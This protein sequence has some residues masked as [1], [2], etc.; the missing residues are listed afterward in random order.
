MANDRDQIT[1]FKSNQTN[2]F[3]Y[4]NAAG[5]WEE[6]VAEGSGGGGGASDVVI[7][8]LEVDIT[9]SLASLSSGISSVFAALTG[10]VYNPIDFYLKLVVGT[11]DYTKVGGGL[12]PVITVLDAKSSTASFSTF[13]EFISGNYVGMGYGTIV[14]K[15]TQAGVA[16]FALNSA[17]D[18]A[19]D[20]DFTTGNHTVCI[21]IN[22]SEV[23]G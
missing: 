14:S 6:F 5:D 2:K 19:S 11:T 13:A 7:K 15:F 9:S 10:K 3:Y 18:L 20:V 1:L 22:Y 12:D 4:I 23:D 17:L 8:N 16:L 21:G